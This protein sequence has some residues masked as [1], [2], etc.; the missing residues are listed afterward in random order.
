MLIGFLIFLVGFLIWKVVGS[1][2]YG[3]PIFII[4]FVIFFIGMLGYFYCEDEK[5]K[6]LGTPYQGPYFEPWVD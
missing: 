6:L 3:W 2:A 5:D 4:G 1:S